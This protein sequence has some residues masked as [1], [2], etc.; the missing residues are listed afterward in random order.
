[1]ND[2][3]VEA[4]VEFLRYAQKRHEDTNLGIVNL[5]DC[6]AV[7]P[8]SLTSLSTIDRLNNAQLKPN[9]AEHALMMISPEFTMDQLHAQGKELYN[10]TFR[11][12]MLTEVHPDKAAAGVKEEEIE[13]A[14]INL[15]VAKDT[16]D[17]WVARNLG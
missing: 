8:S 2:E 15:N 10:K 17:K 7:D 6:P 9:C 4:Y 3:Y 14:A 5:E 12:L 16:L 1:M 13:K 11:K